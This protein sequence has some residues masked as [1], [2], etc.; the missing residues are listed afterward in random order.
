MI[1]ELS[2]HS[3]T[4][5]LASETMVGKNSEQTFSFEIISCLLAALSESGAV[6]GS[7]HYS[8]M[9]QIDGTRTQSGY[10]HMF[11][12]VKA[13]AREIK[14]QIDKGELGTQKDASTPKG[15]KTK[16]SKTATPASGVTKSNKR[17]EFAVMALPID[18][19]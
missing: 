4:I 18:F 7:K 8:L 13:R 15:P 3:P 11:R 16:T 17:G 1:A 2:N 10:E 19:Y 12:A 6:V 5:L 14:E 9:A